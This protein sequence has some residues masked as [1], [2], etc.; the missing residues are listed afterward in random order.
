MLKRYSKEGYFGGVC[1]GLEKHTKCDAWI[2]RC[3]FIASGVVGIVPYA[4]MWIILENVEE[5]FDE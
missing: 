2:W 4:I 3:F 1:H 5:G